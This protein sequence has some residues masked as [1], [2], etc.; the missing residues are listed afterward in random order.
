[1]ISKL[2]REFEHLWTALY[3]EIDL[4][5]EV[6]L[7]PKRRFRFDY[8]HE[9]SKVAIEINGGNWVKGRHTRPQALSDEYEKVLLANLEGYT[10]LFVSEKQI[11]QDYLEKIKQVIE[12]RNV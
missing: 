9:P 4:T 10:V 8:V 7:I 1:M 3:P 6:K 12:Q 11:N 5:A 2:E